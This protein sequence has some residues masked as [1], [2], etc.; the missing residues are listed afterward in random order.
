MVNK[1]TEQSGWQASRSETKS[2]RFWVVELQTD[3]FLGG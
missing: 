2:H 1:A 3:G